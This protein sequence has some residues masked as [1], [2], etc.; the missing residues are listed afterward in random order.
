MKV[1][2]RYFLFL[3]FLFCGCSTAVGDTKIQDEK[4]PYNIFGIWEIYRYAEC[5]GH[6]PATTA[7]VKKSIGE[8]VEF[9]K[10]YINCFGNSRI[11]DKGIYKNVKY[12][13]KIRKYNFKNGYIYDDG[14]DKGTLAAFDIDGAFED[15]TIMV[16]VETE[17]IGKR[18]LE[19]TQK[20]ELAIYGD[21]YFLFLK[22]TK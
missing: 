15:K 5:G 7:L 10:N 9:G 3:M 20:G 12:F 1:I 21:G 13:W 11:A 2:I 16:S 17:N 19:V 4:A 8:K 22:K 6:M 18:A 14:Y